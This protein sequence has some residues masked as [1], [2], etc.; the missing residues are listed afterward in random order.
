[1]SDELTKGQKTKQLILAAA[2]DIMNENGIETIQIRTVARKAG[3]SIGAVYKH[4]P[5]ID[6]LI[7]EVNS[8]TLS[9]I[10]QYMTDAISKTSLPI[11]NLKALA[12]SYYQ[13]AITYPNAWH[14]LFAHHLPENA[15]IPTEHKEQNITLINLIAQNILRLNPSMS[16][17]VASLRAKTAF[18]AVHGIVTFSMEGR[19]IGLTSKDLHEELDFLI[20]RIAISANK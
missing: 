18:A 14:G 20:E 9:L 13:F 17:E 12:Q 10:K 11:D 15:T 8:I 6:T 3:Y 5:D 7:I 1:M 16:P 4:F 19:Y 2:N